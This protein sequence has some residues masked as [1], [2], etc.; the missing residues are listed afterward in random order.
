[1]A[2]YGTIWLQRQFLAVP[3]VVTVSE[4]VYAFFLMQVVKWHKFIVIVFEH[5]F[6]SFVK[7]FCQNTIYWSNQYPADLIEEESEHE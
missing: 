3:E 1:M 6:T 5:A 2:Q 4:Y 7:F